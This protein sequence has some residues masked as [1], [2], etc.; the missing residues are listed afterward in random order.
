MSHW[1]CPVCGDNKYQSL[2][3]SLFSCI[4]CSVIFS[5]PD[6]FN[7]AKGPEDRPFYDAMVQELWF[8]DKLIKQF[9]VPAPNQICILTAFEE[10]GWPQKIF[11]PLPADHQVASR[12][13]QDTLNNLNRRHVTEGLLKFVGDG[14]GEAIIWKALG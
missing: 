1:K 14:T 12:K 4:G 7:T 3:S 8:K 11:D 10:E 6:K 2:E 13:R 5:D 9:R